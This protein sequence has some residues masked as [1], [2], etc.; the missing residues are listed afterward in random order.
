MQCT[1]D[2]HHHV[3]NPCFPQPDGVFEH[4]AAFDAAVDM[5]DAHAPPRDLPIALFLGSCQRFPTWLLDGLND[6]HV[7]Q[8]ERLKAHVLDLQ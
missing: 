7:V 8:R 4:A 3:A 5:F 1:A 2:V 6:L